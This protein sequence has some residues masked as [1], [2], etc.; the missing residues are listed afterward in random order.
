MKKS[1]L[2]VTALFFIT[3]TYC[4]SLEKYIKYQGVEDLAFFAHPTSNY[5]SGTYRIDSDRVR[6]WIDYEDT[7]A[8]LELTYRGGWFNDIRVIHDDDWFDPFA[9]IQF[10][11]DVVMELITE[12]VSDENLDFFERQFKTT[13]E[14]MNVKQLAC[15]Y[16]TVNML[17]F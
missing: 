13:L 8:E 16:M 7:G 5:K 12:N 4:Q 9:G 3:S 10:M 6:I 11:K 14:K 15:M 1:L 2:V 17:G